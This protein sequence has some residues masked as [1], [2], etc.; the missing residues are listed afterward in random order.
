MMSYLN[1]ILWSFFTA[2]LIILTTCSGVRADIINIPADYQSI[3][4]GIDA[5]EER[6]TVLVQPG[7]YRENLMLENTNITLASLF[8]TTG[9]TAYVDS[10]I[11]DGG[12]CE[13]VVII[14]RCNPILCGFTI[15]NGSGNRGGAGIRIDVS[16]SRLVNLKVINNINPNNGGDA[17]YGG[18]IH[19]SGGSNPRIE[20]TLIANNTVE[21][22]FGG[23]V[24]CAWGSGA[25]LENVTLSNNYAETAGSGIYCMHGGSATL[26]NS[27]ITD[28]ICLEFDR[29]YDPNWIRV[30]YSNIGV[31]VNQDSE[32]EF[33]HNSINIGE[34]VLSSNPLFVSPENGDY[35]LSEGSPCIDTGDP[36]SEPDPDG[37]RADMGAFYFHQLT[38]P[39]SICSA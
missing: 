35:R 13:L 17:G 25:I 3:Q 32:N 14:T 7:E 6:D 39:T 4:A 28:Q 5:A 38:F 10:T 34:G 1:K 37:T 33:N 21:H 2:G 18:G 9:D 16:N 31:I 27:I 19:V 29:R 23:G 11:I 12:R 8:L 15:Q 30:N 20:N 24:F 26:L 36:E 22:G